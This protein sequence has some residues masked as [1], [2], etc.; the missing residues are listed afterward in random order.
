L[1]FGG[2]ALAPAAGTAFLLALL[3]VDDGGYF[4]P[5]WGWAGCAIAIVAAAW[6]GAGRPPRPGRLESWFIGAFA[7]YAAWSGISIL[8]SIDR[9]ASV[10]AFE[11]ALL[12]LVASAA[13]LTL[14]RRRDVEI[15][16]LVVVAVITTVCGYG[17]STRLFP[18]ASSFDPGDPVTGYRL[19]APLGYWNALGAYAAIGILAALALLA[20]RQ[21]RLWEAAVAGVAA[22]VLP[23]T[24][25]FTFSRGAWAAGALGAVVAVALSPSPAR[26]LVRTAIGALAPIAAVIAAAH[27][28]ALTHIHARL[29]AAVHEGSRLA[30]VCGLLTL[31]SVLAVAAA[32]RIP[33]PERVIRVRT[34]RG[35]RGGVIAV[36]LSAVVILLVV[37]S[38]LFGE[39]FVHT[40]AEPTPPPE[41]VDVTRR[42]LDLNGNG[43][44]QMW[45]V[46]LQAAEGHWVAGRGGGSFQRSWERSPHANEVVHDAHGL[47]VQTL[48]ELGV[49][50][51]IALV[52]ALFAPLVAG[53]RCRGTPL[54]GPLTGAYLVF[55]LHN[56]V[57]WDWRL[58]GLALTGLVVA[59]LLLLL[60][61]P[62]EV[63]PVAVRWRVAAAG[64]S[65]VI[66]AAMAVAGVGNGALSHARTAVG[67]RDYAAAVGDAELARRFMPWSA[68]P[69]QVLG[70]AEFRAGDIR[71]A[72]QAFDEAVRL[73]PGGWRG[74]LDLAAAS[75]GRQ[76]R[77]A[78]D[79]ARALYP[80]SPEI[81]EF[82]EEVAA[83]QRAR[84]Q[85]S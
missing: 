29:P 21:V 27:Q 26:L 77:A 23:L 37:S 74:W 45:K 53:I 22:V 33:V 5:S 10:Y 78:V 25:F 12:L 50:G 16:T 3:A 20:R 52:V 42:M 11:R 19:S 68:E 72:R 57:D 75:Q 49:V 6:I 31:I 47:Y 51:L 58:T 8:W 15:L 63:Q 61:R 46:A 56:A 85:S 55:V 54:A 83:K 38:L 79:R 84:P 59:G 14:A 35:A 28:S 2:S 32:T 36:A 41:P 71:A 73:D 67:Q 65:C 80:N 1:R 62:L 40:F 34:S 30:L 18:N 70:E 4:P 13:F 69:I 44:A 81:R 82:L 43:R 60:A 39:R 7:L 64:V 76:R 48:A 66:A 24:L 9:T 17:L